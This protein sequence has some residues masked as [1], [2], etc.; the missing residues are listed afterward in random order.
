MDIIIEIYQG[1]KLLKI[2]K[3]K[4][5]HQE[6][7]KNYPE[8]L[9]F[10]TIKW[11]HYEPLTY[12]FSHDPSHHSHA[13][14]ISIFGNIYYFGYICIIYINIDI[15]YHINICITYTIL[16][17]YNFLFS[18]GRSITH[19]FHII[20]SHNLRSNVPYTFFFSNS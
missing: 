10:Q 14:S 19:L 18:L 15:L 6:I 16:L 11:C 12:L 1:G 13:S 4:K 17:I 8:S 3:S 7:Q 2:E 20:Y 9:G 5:F